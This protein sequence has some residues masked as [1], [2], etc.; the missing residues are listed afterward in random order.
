MHLELVQVSNNIGKYMII[1]QQQ[2]TAFF[3]LAFLE[4][5]LSKSLPIVLGKIVC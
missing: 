4:L 2:I 3:V 1:Q 5:A